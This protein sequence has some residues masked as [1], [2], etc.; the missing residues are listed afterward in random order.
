MNACEDLHHPP[1]ERSAIDEPAASSSGVTPVHRRMGVD[2]DTYQDLSRDPR[3]SR[4]EEEYR[5]IRDIG[6]LVSALQRF[7]IPAVGFDSLLSPIRV[8]GI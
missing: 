8:R 7:T 2:D 3:C 6:C 5:R 4:G 1:P